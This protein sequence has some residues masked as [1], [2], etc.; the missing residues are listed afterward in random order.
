[1]PRPDPTTWTLTARWVFPVASPPLERGLLTIAGDRITAVEPHGTR[2]ADL[3]LGNAAVVPGLVNAHTHLDLTGL[4]GQAPYEGDFTDWLRA[5]ISHRGARSP[6]QV[7]ADVRAG[8]AESLAH[9]VTLLGDI[10]AGGMSWDAL[11]GAPLRAVVFFEL[12]G[13][14]Q[15]R[16]DA[17]LA[18]AR[19]WL[20]AH[21]ATPSCRPGLSPHA[22]Y[23][24][25]ANLFFEA[26]RLACDCQ[27]RAPLAFHLAETAEELQLLYQ[28]Q[29]PFVAFLKELGV[30]DPDGLVDNP[31][32]V[33]SLCHQ[34]VPKLFIHGNYLDSSAH[35]PA[36]STIVYCPRTHAF[37]RHPPHPFR[38]FLARGLGVALGTD[39]LASNPDLDLLAEAR[40]LHHRYPEV[41]AARLL[42]MA[43]LDGAR[44]LGWDDETGSLEPGKSADLV[45]LPLPASDEPD[46]HRLV[47][48]GDQA[49][50]QVLCRGRWVWPE[51]NREA[52]VMNL[53]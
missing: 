13:L 42:R 3:D 24:V 52:R 40:F 50:S 41:P 1:M 18:S 44:A 27:P 36:L 48:S 17:A 14:S 2:M 4:R 16:A 10:A 51:L 38:D 33:L 43:T 32:S 34:A 35:V 22:P 31:H 45:V 49:V 11:V 5:V 23:S 6:E 9:G 46:P 37:F 25:R 8:I 20:A 7:Q 30:W 21:P 15:G 47:L 53:S 12:L 28:R 29:G 26:A 39:S 19:A